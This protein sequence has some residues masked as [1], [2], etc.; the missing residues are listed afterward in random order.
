MVFDS[1]NKL[2]LNGNFRIPL[3]NAMIVFP[4]VCE[5]PHIIVR[6]KDFK[7]DGYT[8]MEFIHVIESKYVIQKGEFQ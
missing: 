2:T 1:F 7:D 4:L 8:R 3:D 6:L 5:V